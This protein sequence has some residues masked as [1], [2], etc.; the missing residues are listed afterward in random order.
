MAYVNSIKFMAYVN[1]FQSVLTMTGVME[2]KQI[3]TQCKEHCGHFNL[4]T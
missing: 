3:T 1:S 4:I 2:M